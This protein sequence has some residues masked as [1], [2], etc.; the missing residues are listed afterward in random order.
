MS[1]GIDVARL[2]ADVDSQRGTPREGQRD[3]NIRKW[4]I[5]RRLRF[6]FCGLPVKVDSA[7]GHT[8]V[9]VLCIV[10]IWAGAAEW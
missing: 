9:S 6:K 3:K 1:R 2:S 10:R 4:R 7:D 8:A 5:V